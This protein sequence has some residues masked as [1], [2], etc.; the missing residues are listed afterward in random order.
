MESFGTLRSY[1]AELWK[2]TRTRAD[3]NGQFFKRNTDQMRNFQLKLSASVVTAAFL[4]VLPPIT[5]FSTSLFAVATAVDE[6]SRDSG[7]SG[8][9]SAT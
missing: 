6:T 7:P 9:G 2:H 3:A 5:I 8:E 4:V 1:Y